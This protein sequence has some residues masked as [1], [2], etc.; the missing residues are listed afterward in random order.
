SLPKG[1]RSNRSS[2]RKWMTSHAGGAL[3]EF[4]WVRERA[5]RELREGHFS[6]NV[7]MEYLRFDVEAIQKAHSQFSP[8]SNKI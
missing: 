3:P 8:L 7:T 6:I 5:I 2:D 4:R 1:S